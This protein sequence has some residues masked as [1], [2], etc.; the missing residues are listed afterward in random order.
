MFSM[1]L[2]TEAVKAVENAVTAVV[3]VNPNAIVPEDVMG[4][5]LYGLQ[6]SLLCMGMVFLILILL[7]L[8]IQLFKS[9]FGNTKDKEE[10]TISSEL[11]T[12]VE[13]ATVVEEDDNNSDENEIAAVISAVI[14]TYYSD[15]SIGESKYKIRSFKRVQ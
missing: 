7:M 1:I 12:N 2:I 3:E 14:A 10:D 15:K 13:M 6:V 9:I 11:A 8:M 4:K 5:L